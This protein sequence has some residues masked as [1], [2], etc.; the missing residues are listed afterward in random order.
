AF[1][2]LLGAGREDQPAILK[3]LAIRCLGKT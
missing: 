1:E 3:E 2:Q